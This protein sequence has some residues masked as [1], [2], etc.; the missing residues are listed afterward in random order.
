[1]T[2]QRAH[3]PFGAPAGERINQKQHAAAKAGRGLCSRF[4][5][6]VVAF[7]LWHRFEF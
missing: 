3:H 5:A 1:M 4:G 6:G 7:S 2:Q